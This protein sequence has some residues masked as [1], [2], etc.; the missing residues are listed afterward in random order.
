LL[1]LLHVPWT[2]HVSKSFFLI[3]VV[4]SA[5]VSK[6]YPKILL[7]ARLISAKAFRVLLQMLTE[8]E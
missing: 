3:T 2:C 5:I 6:V 8:R 7:G 4:K 1:S